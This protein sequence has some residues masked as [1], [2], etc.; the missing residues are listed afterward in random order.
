MISAIRSLLAATG[1]LSRESELLVRVPAL[2]R[3]RKTILADLADLV[4]LAKAASAQDAEG[5]TETQGMLAAAQGT[6]E[7][8]KTFLEVLVR[9]GVDL[10]ERKDVKY[11][12]RP[13]LTTTESTA[14]L[15][16]SPVEHIA[17][18]SDPLEGRHRTQPGRL[19]ERQMVPTRSLDEMRLATVPPR[20][21]HG[22]SVSSMSSSTDS[23]N[24]DIPSGLPLL[25][26]RLDVVTALGQ[27]EESLFSVIAALIG[28]IH[29][30]DSTSHPSS[31]ALLIDLTRETIDKVRDLLTL[32]EATTRNP[33]V[34]RVHATQVAHLHVAKAGVYEIT[35]KLVECAELVASKTHVGLGDDEA[36]AELLS[37]AT[38]T[39]RTASECSRL[40]R[41][42]VRKPGS[43]DT[44]DIDVDVPGRRPLV[45]ERGEHTLSALGRK[46]DGLGSLQQQYERDGL[47]SPAIIEPR[48]FYDDDEEEEMMTTHSDE[49]VTMRPRPKLRSTQT[50]P[51]LPGRGAAL[52]PRE[53]ARHR[54]TSMSS[55]SQTPKLM[56]RRSPS[57]SAD[58][59]A[60]ITSG[61]LSFVKTPRPASRQ[62]DDNHET[63]KSGEY[64]ARFWLVSHDHH[65]KDVAFA[66]DGALM[67]A[68]LDVLVEKLTPHDTLVDP[69]F[70]DTFF[71]TF[72][73]F[74]TATKLLQALEVRFDLSPP[75]SMPINDATIRLWNER[76]LTPIRLRVLNFLR[77]WLD[78]HWK[79]EDGEA[80]QPMLDFVD[81]R[82]CKA[83]PNDSPRLR[84]Q[85]VKLRDGQQPVKKHSRKLSKTFSPTASSAPPPPP[86]PILNRALFGALRSGAKGIVIT[87]F[88]ALELARQLTLMESALFQAIAPEDL[89]QTGRRK[90]ASLTAM[91][92][93]SNRITGWVADSILDE[94]DPKRRA[95]LLKFFIKLSARC[96]ELNNFS[97]LFALLA[98]LNSS[99]ILRLKKTWDALAPKYRHLMD[100]LRVLI[101]HSR[102]HREYRQRLKEANLPAL[103]FL[104]LI[105]TD[106]TFTSDGN[107]NF[108]PSTVDPDVKL[109]NY[110]KYIKLARIASDFERY[111]TPYNLAAV[112]DVQAWLERVLAEKGS[113]SVDALY[114]KSRK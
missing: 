36:K 7:D 49:D 47:M 48:R 80:I 31:H 17:S 30:H 83:F 109:I 27:T 51:V 86:T 99:T 52:D 37:L 21:P 26:G 94:T 72:R 56:P 74:T 42:C 107:Q 69:A 54:S 43:R 24:E 35:G 50:S 1:C 62:D 41:V 59:N 76:K 92:T 106:I 14:V 28:H 97:T 13:I 32:V 10:P 19:R 34:E 16:S 114:R 5:E 77:L 4:A 23:S 39:L 65:P 90:V 96:L 20:R 57:K 22:D 105:L 60:V 29:S 11:P 78:A 100:R 70:L 112:S 25:D 85:I 82:L 3:V 64:D 110:D 6:L 9:H 103:P 15:R 68:T 84:D 44:F 98:G 95:A 8:V 111:Q 73:L 113:G 71:L 108:R 61:D 81:E 91:S 38:A 58:L 40:V 66:S 33:N 101:E 79:K 104:G 63:P 18:A 87:D 53:R 46:A 12:L 67:G 75:H 55:P 93:L 2:Q 89:L 88:D 45:G 102:N